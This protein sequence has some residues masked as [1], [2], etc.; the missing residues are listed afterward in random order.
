M[1]NNPSWNKG[2]QQCPVERVSWYDA[3]EFII[4]LNRKGTGI[5]YRMPT[6]A[7]WEFA[8]RGGKKGRGFRYAGSSDLMQVAWHGANAGDNTHPVKSKAA[9]ELGLY[10]MSGNVWE[11]CADLYGDYNAGSQKNPKGP[12]TGTKRIMRGGSWS[13]DADGCSISGRSPNL[14]DDASRLIGFRLAISTNHV[15]VNPTEQ[16]SKA[17]NNTSPTRNDAGKASN[18][19]SILVQ[20]THG[21]NLRLRSTPS[22]EG[23]ILASIPNQSALELLDVDPNSTVINGATGNWLKVRYEGQY[24]WVWGPFTSYRDGQNPALRQQNPTTSAPAAERVVPNNTPPPRKSVRAA[25]DQKI[26]KVYYNRR[27]LE[28]PLATFN[29]YAYQAKPQPC[30]HAALSNKCSGCLGS[31]YAEDIELRMQYNIEYAIMNCPTCRGRGWF[32]R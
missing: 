12:P 3:Q 9:N 6:E 20:T 31:G 26:I 2:C 8:A 32:C 18:A 1:G 30:T 21:S 11:W 23:T 19:T 27:P 24:G 10:D 29:K 28:M 25:Q 17:S 5:I 16:S 22:E 4:R 15:S 14:P 13:S 7:E